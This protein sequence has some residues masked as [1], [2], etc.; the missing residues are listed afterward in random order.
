M[1]FE[2]AAALH[3]T[4]TRPRSIANVQVINQNVRPKSATRLAFTLDR[5]QGTTPESGRRREI[6]RRP[7]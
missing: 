2:K 1:D 4:A 3:S 5:G 6:M 7:V